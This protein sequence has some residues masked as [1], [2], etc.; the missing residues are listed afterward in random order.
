MKKLIPVLL[1]ITLGWLIKLS[2][3]FYRVSQQLTEVQQ[4]LYKNEQK[5]A[6]LND[7]LVA[8]QR[9][10]DEPVQEETK[11]KAVVNAPIEGV[12]PSI[13]VK[14]QLDL[15]QFALEQQQFVYAL[16]HLTQLNQALAHY[17]LAEA[18]KQS[19]HQSIHQDMQSIQQYVIARNTQ[20]D[21]IDAVMKKLDEGFN[22]EIQNNKL[23]VAQVQPE[24]FWQKWLNINVVENNAPE[25]VNRKVILKETQLRVLLAQQ[26]L[27]KGQVLE[28]QTMLNQAI[29][30]LEQLPDTDSQKLKQQ[31]IQ[32]KQTPILP[33]PKLSSL[34]VLG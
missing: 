1:C 8:V 30:Q 29:L 16:E 18:V 14:Q 32:L 25:I 10:T 7:Q 17:T 34:A 31:L 27:T 21:Q 24:H 33:V 26:M 12:N 13:V 11:K 19:L 6:S 28:F 2:Y 15:V 23:K 4:V 22:A 5:N 20:L 9:Q 3:D